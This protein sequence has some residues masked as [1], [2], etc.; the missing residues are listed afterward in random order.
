MGALSSGG[1]HPASGADPT[2]GPPTGTT[3]IRSQAYDVR[4]AWRDDLGPRQR[5][6]TW[7]RDP[8]RL[9]LV[10]VRRD[11][12][13]L[14]QVVNGFRTVPAA[15]H[16]LIVVH[17]PTAGTSYATLET[18]ARV[19]DAHPWEAGAAPMAARIGG[20]GFS[21]AKHEGDRTTPIG[22]FT[23]DPTMYGI[24]PNPGVHFAYHQLV[25]GDYWNENSSS[26]G[27][28]TFVHGADPG[29]PSEA[30]WTVT[31]QY[32]SFAVIQSNT[33]ATPGRGSGIFLHENGA[34]STAGC[35]SLA[36]DELG[37]VLTWLR[38]EEQPRVVIAP[39][40][41]LGQF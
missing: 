18:F 6:T 11:G 16:Q 30:L 9:Q 24:D 34:G 31:P 27:Y 15:T 3:G 35:V 41:S 10:T 14:R 5:L 29:G 22:M 40:G 36:H 13:G 2:T 33:P 37:R 4:A 17:A 25:P 1:G 28:N 39:D 38:P 20:N 32:R 23:I 26:P 8:G 19:D 21:A 7:H 12:S